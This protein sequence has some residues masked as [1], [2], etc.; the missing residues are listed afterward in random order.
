[1]LVELEKQYA[2]Y[3]VLFIGASL[4]EPK[5]RGRIPTFLAEHRIEF[6]VWIGANADDL[7]RLRLGNAVPAT[8]FLDA[9]G[10]IVA[11]ILGQARAGE[12]KERLEWLT[13]DRSGSPPEALVKHL[14]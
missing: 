2:A 14:Q 1:M 8:A 10:H 6:P 7:D 12:V 13:G 11:R 3:G 4:D 5:T 9:D